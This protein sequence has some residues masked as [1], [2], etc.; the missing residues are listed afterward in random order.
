MAAFSSDSAFGSDWNGPEDFS[1]VVPIEADPQYLKE[2]LKNLTDLINDFSEQLNSYIESNDAAVAEKQSKLTFDKKPIKNSS[3]PVTSDGIFQAIQFLKNIPIGTMVRW[4]SEA[5]IPEGWVET[6]G[7]RFTI[8]EYPDLAIILP[9]LTI[10]FEN[11][12][13]IKTTV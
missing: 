5:A 9:G 3:N 11:G 2:S 4:P 7:Q 12:S 1:G 6:A 13:I 10:P 8:T